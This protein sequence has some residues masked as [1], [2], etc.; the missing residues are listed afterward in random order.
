MSDQAAYDPTALGELIRGRRTTKMMDPERPVEIDTI[1]ELCELA[2]WAPNHKR[3]DPWRFAVFSG[4]G[5]ATLGDTIATGMEA[6]GA[7]DAKIL[8]TRTKYL[9]APTVIVVGSLD[10]PDDTTTGENRDAVAAGINNLLLGATAR[11]LATLWSSVATPRLGALLDLCG[12]PADT[13][14]VGAVYLG[15]PTGDEPPGRRAAPVINWID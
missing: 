12:F 6:L 1:R 13:F 4:D 9:R 8:K 7:H 14:C 2:T 15:H 3:T 5:R 10:G 11:G